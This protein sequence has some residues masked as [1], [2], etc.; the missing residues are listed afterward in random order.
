MT[1]ALN[2]KT[3]FPIDD[4][5][6]FGT[7]GRDHLR[8]G[9]G[10]DRLD[11]LSGNDQL[12]G[13]GGNDSLL[14][15]AGDDRLWGG[16]GNDELRG[17]AFAS[18]E[19]LSTEINLM[20]GGAGDDAYYVHGT[21]DRIIEKAGEG[22]DTVRTTVGYTL[23]D[24]VE[25]MVAYY[26]DV[27]DGQPLIGNALDNHITGSSF[28][29]DTL[30]GLDGNDT[31]DG[32]TV[33]GGFLDGGHGN[34]VLIQTF[35]ESLGGAGA[36]LFVAGGRGAMTFPDAPVTVLDF[37][38][39]EGDRLHIDNDVNYDAAEL[40]VTGQLRFEEDTSRLILDFDPST[41]DP[42]SIDQVF[43]LVGVTSFDPGWVS[44]GVLA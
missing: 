3:P 12:R 16:H 43:H 28:G 29:Y 22:T 31:L 19:Q 6:V 9:P 38:A 21:G 42:L 8:G 1:S 26:L 14:G 4:T 5:L 18:S 41:S 2:R 27:I 24:H 40:F 7:P 20:R 30:R 37:H 34:D 23:P 11:G 17:Q 13:Q 36:D 44:V 15:G 33:V 10:D 35:G 39:A 32:G 25:N